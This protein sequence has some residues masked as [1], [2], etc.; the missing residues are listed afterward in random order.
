MIIPARV[1]WDQVK[2]SLDEV[3]RT[4]KEISVISG[5]SFSHAAF[6]LRYG[7]CH[8]LVK[9]SF[10]RFS[11]NPGKLQSLYSKLEGA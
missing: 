10:R 7:A 2:P 8:G 4:A 5:L 9:E 3:A 11:S 1:Y 6:G